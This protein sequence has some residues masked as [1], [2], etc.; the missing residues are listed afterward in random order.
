MGISIQT[1]RIRIGLFGNKSKP[2]NIRSPKIKSSSNQ[3]DS[4]KSKFKTI[5]FLLIF[6][7]GSGIYQLGAT[8]L[9]FQKSVQHIKCYSEF[10]ASSTQVNNVNFEARYKFG[11]RSKGIKIISWNAGSRHLHNKIEEFENVVS[12]F[13]PHI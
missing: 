5:L 13:K 11:N 10:L 9:N 7:L 4:K 12:T 8:S 6:I 2:F 3:N 1:Y